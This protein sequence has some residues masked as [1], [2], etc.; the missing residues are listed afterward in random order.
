MSI[1]A[2]PATVGSNYGVQVSAEGVNALT[3]SVASG[4]LPPG[5]ALSPTTGV[6]TGTP[7]TTGTFPFEVLVADTRGV[8]AKVHL[9][10]TVYPALSLAPTRL[11]PA[12]VGRSYRATVRASGS[13]QPVR[14]SVRSGRLPSRLRLNRKTG[15]LSGRARKPGNYTLTIVVQ[16]GLRRTAKK[17][18]VLTVRRA[19][20]QRA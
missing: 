15:V 12:R 4:T 11:P 14:F 7:A 9:T 5:L 20:L 6:I 10:I 17:T 16:D 3:W 18:Y 8:T 2:P 19:V 13:V 1:A